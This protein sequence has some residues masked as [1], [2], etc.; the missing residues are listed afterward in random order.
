MAYIGHRCIGCGHLAVWHHE[1]GRSCA[2]CT[3]TRLEAGASQLIP[4]WG[5]DGQPVTTITP[6]GERLG[7][8]GASACDKPC[9][10]K[11]YAKENAA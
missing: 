5:L 1:S 3:C 11:K 2:N 7:F 4:T 8:A 9:C 10:V 6:P